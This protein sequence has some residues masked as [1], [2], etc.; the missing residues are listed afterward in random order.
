MPGVLQFG[1]KDWIARLAAGGDNRPMMMPL[2][3]A[4]FDEDRRWK[5]VLD[6][7][8]AADG[9][10]VYAVSSTGIYCRPSCASRRP[11]RERVVFF[12]AA[13]DAER[14]GYRPCRR[15]RPTEPR[16]AADP[17]TEKIRRACV[18]LSNVDGHPSLG[19][20]ARLIGGSP[21]HLQRNFKRIVGVTPREYANACRVG[22]VKR[23]LQRGSDV[24]GALFEAGYGSSSRFYERAVP[25][26]GMT[27]A[28]YRRG[29]AGLAIR[30]ATT[31]S[32]IGEL[33]VASTERGICAV[34]LG[35]SRTALEGALRR[36]FP[37]AELIQDDG[38]LTETVRRIVAHLDGKEPRLDLPLDVRATAFQW[39]VWQALAAIPYGETRRYA[40]IAAA[41]GH[42]R[43]VRAVARACATNP[44][45]I[46][47]PCHRVVPA[48]GGIGGYRW[49]AERKKALLSR[50]HGSH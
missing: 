32:P 25:K 37:N 48:A 47:I 8:R 28:T 2:Q 31:T 29:G 39:Q 50:E 33:L 24:T 22:K 38:S 30:Y 26:L 18:Y 42:P 6:R 4:T 21:Y 17:W 16:P 45:A 19:R 35:A 12:D 49:G 44:A 34:T 9:Q 14:A 43:A 7:D 46:V 41:I 5:V 27:P 36:E 23:E 13:A 15:C 1:R 40:D 10:F 3:H 11:R 20:L